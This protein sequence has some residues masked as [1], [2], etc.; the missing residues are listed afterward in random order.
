V[1]DSASSP[2]KLVS[3]SALHHNFRLLR[4]L[5]K[6]GATQVWPALKAEAYGHG[7]LEVGR[8]LAELP[9]EERPEGYCLARWRE[10]AVLR[11]DGW[12]ERL[13]V[14]SPLAGDVPAEVIERRIE[15][16]VCAE[17]HL[18]RAEA[19]VKSSDEE[20]QHPVHLKIDTGMG[21][22]GCHADEAASLV[23]EILE[24]P[25][26]SL[27][28]IMSHFARA[29][30]I[31]DPEG[32]ETTRKQTDVFERSVAEFDTRFKGEFA[33]FPP[34]IHHANSAALMRQLPSASYSLVRPGLALYG[35]KPHPQ[36]DHAHELQAALSLEA[37]VLNREGDQLTVG[38]GS[39]H[40]LYSAMAGKC[41]VAI[42]DDAF[43]IKKIDA[44]TMV[45]EYPSNL[46]LP[47]TV[48]VIGTSEGGKCT[49]EAHAAAIGT[50]NYEITTRLS[51]LPTQL[52]D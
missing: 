35:L 7:I 50:I 18:S 8:V 48:E 15:L 47:Q 51:N 32:L 19:A 26:L 24:S 33:E 30:E 45:I 22:I 14:M 38:A 1:A 52:V 2:R 6:E 16:T 44:T 39:T 21:R 27:A 11:D 43:L 34:L 5:G 31:D 12:S 25:D 23:E 42:N 10:A 17:E 9:E 37:D 36:I 49:A 46:E 20:Q 28:G 4:S 13:L 41:Y 3:R 40:G 29:D